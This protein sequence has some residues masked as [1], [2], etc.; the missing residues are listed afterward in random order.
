VS[1]L[2]FS[3]SI[4][5]LQLTSSMGRSKTAIS[6]FKAGSHHLIGPPQLS[7]PPSRSEIADRRH[8][9][10][11]AGQLPTIDTVMEE[12][13]GED[14]R[15]SAVGPRSA[16]S[17]TVEGNDTVSS[18]VGQSARL[19]SRDGTPTGSDTTSPT[20]LSSRETSSGGMKR[21]KTV[22]AIKTSS[23]AQPSKSGGQPAVAFLAAKDASNV[24]AVV[25]DTDEINELASGSIGSVGSDTDVVRASKLPMG[26]L[27][28]PLTTSGGQSS[29]FFG[30]SSSVKEISPSVYQNR[31]SSSLRKLSAPKLTRDDEDVDESVVVSPNHSRTSSAFQSNSSRSSPPQSTKLQPQR[32]GGIGDPSLRQTSPVS[33]K[34]DS[35]SITLPSVQQPRTQPATAVEY[36]SDESTGGTRYIRRITRNTSESTMVCL[37]WIVWQVVLHGEGCSVSFRSAFCLQLF[38][39]LRK[40]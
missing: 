12:N 28:S 11:V 39:V 38:T 25:T 16:R 40:M 33:T 32:L 29:S 15:S 14:D 37:V 5:P 1:G 27:L 36:D 3:K 20:K 34:P 13:E 4:G 35:V 23:G 6:M 18:D 31:P 7:K 24:S 8:S 17:I 2:R 26:A 19:N 10:L 21:T 30:A 9:S 22:A